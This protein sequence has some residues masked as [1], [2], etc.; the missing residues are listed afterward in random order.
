MTAIVN[1]APTCCNYAWYAFSL[2]GPVLAWTR[3]PTKVS[4]GVL[5]PTLV[6]QREVEKNLSG[7]TQV[8]VHT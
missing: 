8:Q 3:N 6:L 1:I 5:L 7:Q 4:C 2:W